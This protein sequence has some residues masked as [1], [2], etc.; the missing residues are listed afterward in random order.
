[1]KTLVLVHGAWHGSWCWEPMLPFLKKRFN[2]ININLPGRTY[3]PTKSYKNIC[4]SSFVKHLLD[5]TSDI[6]EMIVVGH[7]M[8]GIVATQ[9]A[10]LIPE[11]ITGLV[12]LTAF[13][14][15]NGESLFDITKDAADPGISSEFIVNMKGNYIEINKSKRAKHI[16]FNKT[17]AK[18]AAA[19]L[20]NLCPEPFKAFVEPA[21]Y[22]D[23]I[24]ARIPKL[25][26]K[27]TNDLAIQASLQDK[28]IKRA[29]NAKVY[30][31][32]C[33]HSPFISCPEELVLP[34]ISF[35][36]ELY[37]PVLVKSTT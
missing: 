9:F 21:E 26:I 18:D 14:P 25:Y 17:A 8:G 13:V 20:L 31:L 29:A 1:M 11:R 6:K 19:A 10:T 35:S 2:V 16:L 3:E 12:Y 23:K 4:L 32:D 22:C 7:S 37:N 27:C 36:N 15:N 5:K 24:L 34:I 28:M 33:D 30:N